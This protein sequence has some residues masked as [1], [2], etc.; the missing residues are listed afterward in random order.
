MSHA[1]SHLGSVTLKKTHHWLD[2]AEYATLVGL[3]VGSI[4]SFVFSQFFYASAPLSLLVLLNL[5]NRNRLEQEMRRRTQQAIAQIDYE[6]SQNLD[7]LNQQIQTLPTTEAMGSL[8]K[9]MLV[10]NREMA[11]RLSGEIKTLQDGVQAVLVMIER[12]NLGT[13]RQ[14][15][16]VVRKQYE[17]LNNGV[18]SLTSQVQQMVTSGRF[19]QMEHAIAQLRQNTQKLEAH[20]QSLADQTKPT[21]TALQDQISH[22]NRQFQKLPPPFD[23]SALRQEVAELTRMVSDL[24]PKRDLTLLST[25]LQRLQ[26]QQESQLAAE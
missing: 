6:V 18:T 16:D 8:R 17:S 15:L 10:K 13:V 26:T 9:S 3:G 2:I 5:A 24:V 14:D 21:L 25:E 20:I 1:H 19:D 7:R 4:T 22:L 23:A 12:L 11:E